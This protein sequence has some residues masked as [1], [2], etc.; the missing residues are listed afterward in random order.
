MRVVAVSGGFDPL[1]VGHLRLFRAARKLGDHLLVILNNDE[2][3]RAKKGFVLMPAADRRELLLALECVDS[4]R[5][6]DHAPVDP[7]RSVVH[8]LERYR[9]Q[10]FANGGDRDEANT[11]EREACR[12]LGIELAYGVGGGKYR[13]SSQLLR[14]AQ[15]ECA[16]S[17]LQARQEERGFCLLYPESEVAPV[18][19]CQ[20]GME[21][22]KR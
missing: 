10:V 7:D 18:N 12:S 17:F 16:T 6:T 5:L 13:S 21:K 8:A 22:P 11:L 15:M 9:P 20:Q 2:W 4:V 14:D 19:A 3:L 1:H